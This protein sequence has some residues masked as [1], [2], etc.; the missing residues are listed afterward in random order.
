MSGELYKKPIYGSDGEEI[1]YQLIDEDG[2]VVEKNY[3]EDDY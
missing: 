1:G 3:D 2:F